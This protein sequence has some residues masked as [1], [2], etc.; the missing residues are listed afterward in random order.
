M[1]LL[2]LSEVALPTTLVGVDKASFNLILNNEELCSFIEKLCQWRHE[3]LEFSKVMVF[4]LQ[5]ENI[6]CF[7]ISFHLK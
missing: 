2:I 6:E 7:H 5:P 1:V 3:I 4:S